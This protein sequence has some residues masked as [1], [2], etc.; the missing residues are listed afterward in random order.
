MEIGVVRCRP[1]EA[2]DSP[3]DMGQ[4]HILLRFVEAVNLI[5]EEY[6]RFPPAA[7]AKCGLDRFSRGS[8]RRWTPRH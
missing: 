2:H 7:L 5:D 1:D 3:L 6:R 8:P 4:Q